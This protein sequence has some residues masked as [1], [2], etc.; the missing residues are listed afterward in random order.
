MTLGG[1][2]FGGLASGLDT[3]AIIDAILSVEGRPIRALENRKESEQHKLTLLGTFEGLVN[4]LRDRARELQTASD[5]FAH[6]LTVGEEGIATFTLGG[7]AEAGAHT[8]EVLSLASADRYAFA[9]V[10][11]PEAA[12]GTGTVSFT[13][14]GTAYSVN[15]AAGSDN[16]NDIAA[17]INTEAGADV[18][19]SV[20]N[21][22]TEASPSYQLVIAGDDTG[23]DFVVTGLTS[24]VAGLTGATRVST[25]TNAEVVVDGLT[26]ERSTN[27]FSDVLPGISFTVSRVNEGSPMSFTVDLDPAGIKANIQEFVDAYNDVIEFVN[28]Q[29]TFSLE[30]G[31]GGELF[32]DSALDAVRGTLRRVLFSVDTGTSLD[33]DGYRSFGQL[34]IELSSDGTLEIDEEALEEKLNGDLDAFSDFFRRA[35]DEATTTVDEGGMFVRLKAALDDLLDDSAYTDAGGTS[36]PLDGLFDARRVAVQR[37]IKDFDGEI[38]R[39]EFRL[40]K[41]EESLVA[42]FSA[43]EELMSGLQAQQAFLNAG[44]LLSGR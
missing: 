31:T 43:L 6:E 22:G 7:G 20:V 35:D 28:E 40:E 5:F 21:V 42:Q 10:S 41:L 33:P 19:A 11:D 30:E 1:I 44:G 9:G 3:G 32:G 4:A 34:G 27:L 38:E 14:D 18:T 39:L 2:Q 12:L 24:T 36:H 25:A 17:A 16:L 8:L 29:N 15:V 37:Q 13:Y 23:A 26:V